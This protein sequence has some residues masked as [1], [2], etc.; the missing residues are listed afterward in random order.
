M[1]LQGEGAVSLSRPESAQILQGSKSR[2]AGGF[3]KCIGFRAGARLYGYLPVRGEFDKTLLAVDE[4]L[5]SAVHVQGLDPL[6]EVH[7]YLVPGLLVHTA[8]EELTLPVDREAL[9]QTG[10]PV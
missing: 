5:L 9:I 3:Q 8:N 1:K 2:L 6:P 7:V 10:L 4:V